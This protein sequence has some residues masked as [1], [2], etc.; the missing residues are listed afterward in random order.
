MPEVLFEENVSR[1]PL[2]K[3]KYIQQRD[4]IIPHGR[5]AKPLHHSKQAANA[6][7]G[8]PNAAGNH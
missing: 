6:G 2:N 4:S 1:K 8:S 7:S 3:I 5:T